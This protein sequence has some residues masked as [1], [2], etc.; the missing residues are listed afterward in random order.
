MKYNYEQGDIVDFDYQG[1]IG[2]GM[3]CGC[4]VTEL[5]VIGSHYIVKVSYA[6]GID[7]D[8]YPFDCIS[9]PE[10]SFKLRP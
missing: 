2:Y 10:C 6:E 3:I 1:I 5:P 9:I 4:S 8:E 7:E